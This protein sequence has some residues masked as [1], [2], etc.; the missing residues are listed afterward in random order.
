VRTSSRRA[1]NIACSRLDICPS[2]RRH[3][4][5][6]CNQLD[7][8]GLCRES[9]DQV[10]HSIALFIDRLMGVANNRILGQNAILSPLCS[11]GA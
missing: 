8:T 11:E 4:H 9:P 2:E 7:W 3:P 5:L 1:D 6:L 10:I